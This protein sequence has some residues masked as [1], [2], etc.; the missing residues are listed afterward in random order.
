MMNQDPDGQPFPIKGKL[1]HLHWELG[2]ENL[3]AKINKHY[4]GTA[5]V[6]GVGA[7]VGDMFG[8]VANSAMLA[9]YDGADTQ[10]FMCL[11]DDQPACGQFGGA[12]HLPEGGNVKA[13]VS[14]RDGVLYVHAAMD[15]ARGMV[16]INHPWGTRAEMR[17]NAK[18]GL[19]C[20]LGMNIMFVIFW[21]IGGKGSLW[22][23]MQMS[24][25]GGGALCLL[26]TLWSFKDL[27]G[28]AGP[29]TEYFRLLGFENPESVNLNFPYKYA[30][31][32]E[33]S[34]RGEEVPKV[35]D[36]VMC[37]YEYRNVYSLRAAIKAG[38]AKLCSPSHNAG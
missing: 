36:R 27:K 31:Y 12:E 19:F 11:I 4:K 9:M 23:T 18:L 5:V 32:E 25:F 3:L 13:V 37:E 29:S 6:T 17:A 38:K 16:W 33:C 2:S 20:F 8:Q 15:E 35:W 10:N 30:L 28:I 21:L 22:E 34:E 14:R 24:L 1:T 7:A 26:M